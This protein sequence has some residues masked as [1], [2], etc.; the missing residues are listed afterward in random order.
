MFGE[1]KVNKELLTS[2]ILLKLTFL[3][4]NPLLHGS[5][6]NFWALKV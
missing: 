6:I 2:F 4:T 5:W 3:I 1:H